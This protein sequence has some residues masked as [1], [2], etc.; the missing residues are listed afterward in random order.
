MS[1]SKEVDIALEII[2]KVKDFKEI[3]GNCCDEL[4]G[5]V[6]EIIKKIQENDKTIEQLVEEIQNNQKVI[7]M[8]ENKSKVSYEIDDEGFTS[9]EYKKN[10][11][12]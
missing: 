6:I 2:E 12:S 5:V 3:A 1:L 10:D 4:V 11:N 8:Y 9:L 7:E